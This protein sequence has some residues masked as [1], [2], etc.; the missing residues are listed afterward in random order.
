MKDDD[1]GSTLHRRC[2]RMDSSLKGSTFI[3]EE[4]TYKDIIKC[5]Y[6]EFRE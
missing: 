6:R 3:K 2:F 5:L 1:F 4:G